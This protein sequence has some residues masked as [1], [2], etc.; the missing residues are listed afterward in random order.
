MELDL[1]SPLPPAALQRVRS[2][3][4]YGVSLDILTPPADIDHSN[5]PT[6]DT[7]ADIVRQRIAEYADF[8]AIAAL[9]PGFPTPF[10]IQ[11]L[12]MILKPGRKPRLVID[13]SRNLNQ[14]LAYEYFS[15]S[16]VRDA[17]ELSTPHCWYSKLDLSNCFLSFPLHPSALPY[18]IFRFEGQLYQFVRMPF[19]L[20]SAPRICTE[21]LAVVAYRMGLDGIEALIRYLDDFLFLDGSESASQGSLASAMRIFDEFGLVVNP[22]KTEGPAQR[23]TFLGV[24][25]DS[26]SQTVACTPER[27]CE[28]ITLLHAS[29]ARRS[30][31]LSAL[32]S[33]I[34]KLQFATQVLPGFRPF[35]HRLQAV[36]N[37]RLASIARG[38]GGVRRHEFARAVARVRVDTGFRAD[39]SFWLSHLRGWN[40]KQRWRSARSAPF[41]FASDASLG[42]F[43]FYL[44]TTPPAADVTQWP[45]H[46]RVG[47]GF[48]GVYSP[49]DSFLHA[50]SSQMT[51]CE[52]FAVF[53]ALTTYADVLRDTCVLFLVDNQ[54][55]VHVLNKQATRSERLAGLLRAI[56]ALSLEYNISIYARHR[57][58][59]ENVLADF[60]SRPEHHGHSPDVVAAFHAAHPPL[61]HMLRS[62]SVV[63]S[64]QFGSERERP[65]VPSSQ[66]SSTPETPSRPTTPSSER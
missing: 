63:H 62:V 40:G 52:M 23:I 3:V 5:T 29:V 8:G 56:Y 65:S 47:S 30:I 20:C 54:T 24:L 13:L 42:G 25:F 4:T 58:G 17:M 26:T 55:D 60:L 50:S 44:E 18:F 32:E 41:V 59:V 35:T 6:I 9:P 38:R 66:A 2:W 37:A 36:L 34:G 15:Y 39:V 31:R 61:M 10:G 27:V 28:L 14:H 64:R 45:V 49:E 7:H 21:M 11:P 43:G 53:A 12:H 22:E 1:A 57:P 51:W 33:L 48:M 46:L 16:S 19:G